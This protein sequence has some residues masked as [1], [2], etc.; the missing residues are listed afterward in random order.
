MVR[1]VIVAVNV[2]GTDPEPGITRVTVAVCCP[3]MG[4]GSLRELVAAPA[5]VGRTPGPRATGRPVA[6]GV[7]ATFSAYVLGRLNLGPI[8]G[9]G[10][11]GPKAL[12]GPVPM[13]P[14]SPS[15]VVEVA[16]VLV[17]VAED[18]T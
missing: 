17:V 10:P 8:G 14:G 12:V 15:S 4:P 9:R 5:A 2:L 11:T 6:L 18:S 7:G 16:F 3:E 13:S 1:R